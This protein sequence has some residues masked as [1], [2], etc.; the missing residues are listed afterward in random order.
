MTRYIR[1]V[2]KFYSIENDSVKLLNTP[3]DI[4]Y[5]HIIFSNKVLFNKIFDIDKFN[6]GELE[7]NQ[8][9]VTQ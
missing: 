6:I 5:N 2:I 1:I 3:I 7:V 9:S 8:S 4:F